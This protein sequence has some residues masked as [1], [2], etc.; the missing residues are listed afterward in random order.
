[1]AEETP[2][3]VI[4]KNGYGNL[5]QMRVLRAT[6]QRFY[7]EPIN[8][9]GI[10]MK[11]TRPN[12]Y[13]DRSDVLAEDPAEGVFERL[14][15]FDAAI[16]HEATALRAQHNKESQALRERHAAGRQAIINGQAVIIINGQVIDG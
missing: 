12:R 10:Y 8:D 1:M 14:C 2:K 3:V 15:A 5:I 9:D 6:D 7:G 13:V 11:G 4:A 16:D